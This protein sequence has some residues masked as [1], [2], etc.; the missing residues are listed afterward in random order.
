MYRYILVRQYYYFP[1]TQWVGKG[2]NRVDITYVWT[3]SY[4]ISTTYGHPSREHPID[5]THS[6]ETAKALN[7]ISQTQIMQSPVRMAPVPSYY[8]TSLYH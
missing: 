4:A 3:L 5:I 8:L 2:A 6:S 1:E 7:S